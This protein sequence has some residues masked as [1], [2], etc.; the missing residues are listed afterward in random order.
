MEFSIFFLDYSINIYYYN[1]QARHKKTSESWKLQTFL[2]FVTEDIYT[3]RRLKYP[4]FISITLHIEDHMYN[5]N[6]SALSKDVIFGA[7]NYTNINSVLNNIKL[8]KKISITNLV[9]LYFSVREVEV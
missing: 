2:C 6:N 7:K 8:F 1:L 3:F 9:Y 5:S 4:H